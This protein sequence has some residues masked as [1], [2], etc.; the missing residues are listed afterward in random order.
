MEEIE[1]VEKLCSTD[2]TSGKE[3]EQPEANP[4]PEVVTGK[5][6]LDLTFF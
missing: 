5:H 4:L 6:S 3:T 1:Q 2:K